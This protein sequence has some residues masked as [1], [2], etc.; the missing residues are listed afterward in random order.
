MNR[1]L[2]FATNDCC[3]FGGCDLYTTKVDLRFWMEAGSTDYKADMALGY[4]VR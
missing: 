1:D 4:W 2:N 3:V